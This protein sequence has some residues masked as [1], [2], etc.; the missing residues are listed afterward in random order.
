VGFPSSVSTLTG[1]FNKRRVGC[2]DYPHPLFFIERG[3]MKEQLLPL[4]VGIIF[5]YLTAWFIDPIE[6]NASLSF[7][8][9]NITGKPAEAIFCGMIVLTILIFWP[10]KKNK[11]KVDDEE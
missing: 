7:L 9:S 2:G 11:E 4:V 6:T 3:K 1:T 8:I 10:I 5:G